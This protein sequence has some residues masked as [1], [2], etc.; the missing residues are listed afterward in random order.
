MEDAVDTFKLTY[1]QGET[2]MVCC[3]TFI[4]NA[5]N[6]NIKFYMCGKV[7]FRNFFYIL[8]TQECTLSS[9]E[10]RRALRSLHDPS[11][12][13]GDTHNINSVNSSLE[14]WLL[15]RHKIG[16]YSLM[17]T[18]ISVSKLSGEHTGL[19]LQ[20][21]CKDIIRQPLCF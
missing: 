21:C 2:D 9:K 12:Q 18:N 7:L 8:F 6:I 1:R 19:P 4:K 14:E 20:G 15:A 3:D 5:L 10:R 11:W 17:S 16:Q 13:R